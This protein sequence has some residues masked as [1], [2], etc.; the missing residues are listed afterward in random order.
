[1]ASTNDFGSYADTELEQMLKSEFISESR[2]RQIQLELEARKI[3]KHV[4]D[5]SADTTSFPH[6]IAKSGEH[7][8]A[9]E[10][11]IGKVDNSSRA[12]AVL[13]IAIIAILAPP[14]LWW[15]IPSSG[16]IRLVLAFGIASQSYWITLEPWLSGQLRPGLHQGER[17]LSLL[18]ALLGSIVFA[19]CYWSRYQIVGLFSVSGLFVASAIVSFVVGLATIAMIAAVSAVVG[20]VREDRGIAIAIF[21]RELLLPK[22]VALPIAL[23]A[24]WVSSR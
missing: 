9:G 15:L 23:A 16:Y 19:L 4:A 7:L 1:M 10:T 2:A 14:I 5:G 8:S 20:L 21:R 13:A 17:N 11:A 3:R 6:R 12:G 22:L 24:M 18:V